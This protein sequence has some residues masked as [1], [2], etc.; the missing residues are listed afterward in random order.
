LIKAF[1]VLNEYYAKYDKDYSQTQL[2]FN[3][4]L[5][6]TS[7]VKI[8]KNNIFGVDLDKQAVDIAQLNLLLKIAEKE[9]RLPLLQE[10]IKCGN[11]LIDDPAIA[12]DK[13]FKWEEE[14][15]EVMKEGGF[16]VVIGNPPWIS[17]GLRGVG[18]MD[19]TESNFYRQKYIS[20]EYKLSTYALFIERAITLLADQG[21]FSFI[22]P[23]SFLLGR[24][25]SKL[26]RF[27][28]YNCQIK[29]ILL[30]FY[31]VFS[32][33]A[34]TGRNVIIVLKKEKDK[35]LRTKSLMDIIKVN[36]EKDFLSGNFVKFSYQQKYF[37]KLVYNRFRLFFNKK[38]MELIEHIEKG[39]EY[40][41]K[42]MIGHTGVRSLIGQKNIISKNKKTES[43][44]KGLISGSQIG[45]YWLKY[46]GDYINIDP[47]L[48][49]KGG[50]EPEVI[51]NDK[52]MIRQTGDRI[53]ATIDNDK[54]YH[55]NNI[56]S[57]NLKDKRLD[58]KYILALLNSKMMSAY[59]LLVTLEKE[60]AMAQ[61]D[62]ETLEKLPIK[63][64][65]KEKQQPLI[66][67]VDKML[68]LNK[69]LN[70]IGDKKTDER[71]RIEEEIRKTD[72]EIDALVYKIYG[73]TEEEKKI[74]EESLK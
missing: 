24:Y 50:W 1:D 16:D 29:K 27:I 57:F 73:I 21:Y 9:Q 56:H 31:D 62:I 74:I 4:G 2:D 37:E 36:S 39:S 3:T 64:V 52:L 71:A 15:K 54:Y 63:E 26:R 25:F 14:F 51:L 41:G 34:T 70:E 12:G 7:K 30:T 69:R 46:D 67:L 17:F 61:T 58:I 28:L 42:F 45:R 35:T 11:S 53:Y 8:L 49:N 32:K 55:L 40:L 23:D 20:A 13:A 5:S 65:E 44:K 43:W 68:S 22:L 6:F 59:Y 48:L 66:N 18:K 47:K 10:N 33:E 19:K 72:A 60:R 38:E